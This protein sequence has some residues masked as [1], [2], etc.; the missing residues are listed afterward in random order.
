MAI[1]LVADNDLSNLDNICEICQ[2]FGHQTIYAING[3][4]GIEAIKKSPPDLVLSDWKM[5]GSEKLLDEAIACNIPCVVV[6]AWIDL[7]AFRTIERKGALLLIK[8]FKFEALQ[9]LIESLLIR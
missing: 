5:D 6:T 9:K 8:P 1:I 3:W 4:E 7:D 2:L